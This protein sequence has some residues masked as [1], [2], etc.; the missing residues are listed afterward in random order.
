MQT[1]A[2]YVLVLGLCAA[3]A[4]VG[5][6]GQ[7]ESAPSQQAI[8]PHPP[9]GHFRLAPGPVIAA[10]P[11]DD[12]SPLSK[13]L[14]QQWKTLCDGTSSP[15][16][17]SV[18]FEIGG[19]GEVLGQPNAGGLE[20]STD[21]VVAA[22]ARSAFNVVQSAEPYPSSLYGQSVTLKFDTCVCLPTRG[23]LGCR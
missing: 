13:R 11:Q 14:R 8:V 4:A 18:K 12:G 19:N 5:A 3:T 6:V 15:V 7:T 22:A 1:T 23:S 9:G 17:L 20:F 16:K 10:V 2:M 21:P